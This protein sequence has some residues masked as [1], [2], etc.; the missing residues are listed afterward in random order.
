MALVGAPLVA[1]DSL[2]ARAEGTAQVDPG[3]LYS[4][5]SSHRLINCN[6]PLSVASCSIQPLAHCAGCCLALG[7]VTTKKEKC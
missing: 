6:R 5:T 4:R 3:V 2:G 1:L 7:T